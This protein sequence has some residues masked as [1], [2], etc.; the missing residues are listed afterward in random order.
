MEHLVA[1]N[2]SLQDEKEKSQQLNSRE[3]DIL[4]TKLATAKKQ[5]ETKL[6]TELGA[7]YDRYQELALKIET[8][9]KNLASRYE[10]YERQASHHIKELFR[11]MDAKLAEK[12][13]VIRQLEEEINHE[14]KEKSELLS[15]VGK[16]ADMELLTIQKNY[17]A[18]IQLIQD[19]SF[20]LKGENAIIKKKFTSAYKEIEESK[21]HINRLKAENERILEIIKQ[22]EHEVIHLK[23]NVQ[24][25]DGFI[26]EKEFN[27]FEL[28]RANQN[29][30]K[31][32]FV[33]DHQIK[34]FRGQIEPK[35]HDI[36][37]MKSYVHDLGRELE[38]YHT[39]NADLQRAIMKS[40]EDL[41]KI[42]VTQ[43]REKEKIAITTKTVTCITLDIENCMRSFQDDYQILSVF[44]I[45]HPS[46]TRVCSFLIS[47]FSNN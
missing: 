6:F 19:E 5:R 27:I 2:T 23:K 17:E 24:D 21:N 39:R 3:L 37:S 45:Y 1:V 31:H 34:E 22:L 12:H 7:E 25:R 9:Q 20:R 32:K 38:D 11:E 35:Q 33:V 4:K 28:K 16:D 40:T 29:L 44:T 18:K 30:E 43:Q 13:E 15:Q 46:I 14:S 8:T 41:E 26:Q 10:Q 47:L 36:S 42:K